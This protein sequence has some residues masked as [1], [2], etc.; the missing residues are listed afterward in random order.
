MIPLLIFFFVVHATT[1]L[2]ILDITNKIAYICDCKEITTFEAI[3]VGMCIATPILN[4]YILYKG[5]LA[6]VHFLDDQ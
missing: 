2:V 5:V 6:L 3:I 1:S 4:M